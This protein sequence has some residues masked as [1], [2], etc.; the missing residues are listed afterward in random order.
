MLQDQQAMAGLR[1]VEFTQGMAGPWIGR[2]LAWCG[3]EV[4]RVESKSVPGVV[5]LYIS[6]HEPERGIQP[7]MS[8]WFTDWDAGKLFVAINLKNPQGVEVAHKLVARADVVIE[9][10][11]AGAMQ[12]LGLGWP[13]LEKINPGMIGLSSSGFGNQG[14]YSEYVTWGPNVEAMSGLMQQ[15]GFPDSEGATTQYAYPDAL[16]ALHGLYALLCALEHRDKTGQGQR[17]EIAQLETTVAMLGPEMMDQ[18]AHNRPPPRWGNSSRHMSPHGCYPCAG[19]D[20]FCV[21][22]I[23]SDQEW[24]R[25]GSIAELAPLVEDAR[26]QTLLG[27]QQRATEI[28]QALTEWTQRQEAYALVEALQDL[29]LAAGVVQNAEDQYLNDPHL[30]AR[31]AF[32]KIPHLEK[33]EV[34]AVGIPLGLTGT[35][36]RTTRAGAKMGED[37]VRVFQNLLGLS[38]KEYADY[39]DAGAIEE[40]EEPSSPL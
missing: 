23:R 3:A 31:G 15:S 7:A 10:N 2:M 21:L 18:L 22:S 9:N 20:R 38:E 39:L 8:P 28:D 40:G 17:I 36:G 29:G 33:G 32:E 26:H 27:R 37:N 14:P 12:K 4:I 34:T 13:E 1:V 35:P 16:S 5:R 6:P 30:S 24:K 11:R 25:L 19:S